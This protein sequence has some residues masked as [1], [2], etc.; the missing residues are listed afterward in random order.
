MNQ[1]DTQLLDKE[2]LCILDTRQIQKFMFRSN[3]YVDTLGGSDLMTHILDDGISFALRAIDPPLNEG[4][5]DLSLDP[6]AA[7]P[8]FEDGDVLF[9]LMICAAGNAMFLARSGRLAQKIIRKISRY[10]LDHA[11]SLNL[12]AAAVEKT[13]D[14]GHD[15][16]ELY[17]K[18]N[19][20][21]TSAVVS[22]PLG[23]LPVVIRESGTGEPVIGRDASHG[24][25]IS[26]S[27]FLRRR[28]AERRESVVEFDALSATRGADGRRYRAVLH[29][30]GN[31]VGIT[32]GR[33]LQNTQDY[34]K[35]IRTRRRINGNLKSQF[36][37]IMKDTVAQLREYQAA[38]HPQSRDFSHDFQ[39]IH[40]SGDDINCMCRADLAFPF[41]SFFYDNL[42]SAYLG[43]IDG[44][45]VPL[46]CC[47]GICFAAEG[48]RFHAAFRMAQDCCDSAKASAKQER[49]LRE[50]LACSWLDFMLCDSDRFQSLDL[51][52]ERSYVTEGNVKL[53]LGPYCLDETAKEQPCAYGAFL[54]RMDA[55]QRLE[56]RYGR[57][58]LDRLRDAYLLGEFEFRDRLHRLKEQGTDLEALL[59]PPF[60][61]DGDGGIRAAWYDALNAMRFMPYPRSD[62]EGAL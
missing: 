15:V 7:I 38:L 2:V 18:L 57:R 61:R 25:C 33:L 8:Y 26:R 51:L 34:Q 47:T 14:L 27:S 36:A 53:I 42:R 31:N 50:G 5:Y 45:R 17:R 24:D 23:A 35:G 52:R 13:D 49:N 12:A 4:E 28:E 20:V 9:Q 3:S 6:D 46:Y 43:E 21:K 59:G 40:A 62:R 41:V 30:D 54:R 39:I 55:L 48:T 56:Q 37:R 11:Y 16:F 10:Y 29:V 44:R 32:L 1:M 19:N 60:Y 22:N 58:S